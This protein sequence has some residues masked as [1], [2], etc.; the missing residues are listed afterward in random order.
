ME[1]VFGVFSN[2]DGVEAGVGSAGVPIKEG[3]VFG[4]VVGPEV[5]L[6]GFA[7][8]GVKVADGR[9]VYL[10][11]AARSEDLGLE[12]VEGAQE[13]GEMVVPT[14][15]DVAAEL[16]AMGGSQSP[17]LPVKGLVVAEFF[18]E[19]VCAERGGEHAARKEA[20]G[21]R[22]RDGSAVK[23]VFFDVGLALD[24]TTHSRQLKSNIQVS[25]RGLRSLRSSWEI[26]LGSGSKL[27]SSIKFFDLMIHPLKLSKSFS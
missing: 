18:G 20:G 13:F 10:K 8:A 12:V 19:K 7:F 14:A 1:G 11:I 26:C 4:M 15:H 3:A 6:G 9:F 2:E 22:W 16:D 21:E 25:S 17:F 24:H 5:A 23:V 27:Q